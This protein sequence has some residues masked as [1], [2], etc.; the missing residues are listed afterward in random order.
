MSI[1]PTKVLRSTFFPRNSSVGERGVERPI[2]KRN[3]SGGRIGEFVWG[4]ASPKKT[5][6]L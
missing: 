1:Q 4:G 3:F 2:Q 5:P 6:D